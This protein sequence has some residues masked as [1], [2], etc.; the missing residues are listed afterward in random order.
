[1][2]AS[3]K[4]IPKPYSTASP[5][6]QSPP[7]IAAR[8]PL[9]LHLPLLASPSS[10]PPCMGHGCKLPPSS[11]R[12]AA[13]TSLLSHPP[14][15]HS[16]LPRPPLH[17]D[18]LAF[19]PSPSRCPARHRSTSRASP[20]GS[21][22]GFTP[23]LPSS[24]PSAAAPCG[25]CDRPSEAPSPTWRHKVKDPHRRPTTSS[26]RC[27]P[28]CRPLGRTWAPAGTSR[29]GSSPRAPRTPP[30]RPPSVTS[31]PLPRSSSPPCRSLPCRLTPCGSLTPPFPLLPKKRKATR[32]REHGGGCYPPLLPSALPAAAARFHLLRRAA[33]PPRL[34]PVAT[35][36]ARPTNPTSPT[37]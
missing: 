23:P 34:G 1:L 2:F 11:D 14:A 18:P 30:C 13:A 12:A 9:P 33:A 32:G 25:R 16:H 3:Y 28:R 20:T 31:R 27:C 21:V 10:D 22:T 29:P 6:P 35:W 17:S 15:L 4:R 5:S 7:P 19:A 24:D 8:R 26:T 36:Y 37:I